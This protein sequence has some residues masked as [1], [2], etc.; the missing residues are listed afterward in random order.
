[1]PSYTE[2]SSIFGSIMIMRT[3]SGVAL[4]SSDKIMAFTPTDLPD[5]VVPATK[6]CG[7]LAR[8]VTTGWPVMSCPSAR[9]SLDLLSANTGE[10]NTSLR[11]IICRLG[12]G[13]SKPMQVL[14]GMVSTT[15]MA[16]TPSERARSFSRLI[17]ELPRTPTSGSIS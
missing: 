5:P 12:L 7:A 17:T 1:M 13:S 6:R 4:N 10:L 15:R 3:S 8:S 11:R 16:A 14:P 2:S 9:V